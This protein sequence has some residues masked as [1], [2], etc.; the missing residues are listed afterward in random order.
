MG[1]FNDDSIPQE[2]RKVKLVI[3]DEDK[4]LWSHYIVGINEFIKSNY[5][6]IRRIEDKQ[7]GW[8]FI[9]PV[10]DK[11]ELR[12]VQDKLMFYLWDS[13]F[14]R[15]KRPLEQFLVTENKSVK[16]ATYS[17]FLNLIQEFMA[18]VYELGAKQYDEFDGFF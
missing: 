14:A 12:Q 8:W 3:N 7:I 4:G 15:D 1:K 10:N 5:Q 11:V 16:L 9:K 2:L 13:V 6:V 17:D 18:K